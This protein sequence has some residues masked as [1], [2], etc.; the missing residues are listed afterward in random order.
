LSV[1]QH[2]AA[3]DADSLHAIERGAHAAP[4]SIL[5]VHYAFGRRLLRVNAPGA[6]RVEARARANGE[7]LAVLDQ[8]QTPGLFAGP[9]DSEAPY[10]LRVYWPGRVDEHEDP[11]SFASAL[12]APELQLMRQS[13]LRGVSGFLG[14]HVTTLEDVP[15]VRFAYWAPDA[16]SVAVAGDFNNWSDCRH[17]M[18]QC[19]DSG[20]WEVF[21]PRVDTGARYCFAVRQCDGDEAALIIDPF[22]RATETAPYPA[23]IVGAVLQHEWR[24]DRFLAIRRARRD[25]AAPVSIYRIEP[26]AWLARAER[27]AH[28]RQLSERLPGF[29][30]ALGFSHIQIALTRK[31]APAWM[32]SPPDSLGEPSAFADFIDVC[33]EAGL[34]VVLDWD[35]PEFYENSVAND[36]S[37]FIENILVD[38]AMAWLEEFHVDGLSI[39]V[40][41]VTPNLL[42]RLRQ[43]MDEAA[44]GALLIVEDA[45]EAGHSEA[46]RCEVQVWRADAILAA[47][48][49]AADVLQREGDD[50]LERT[51]LPITPQTLSH[52]SP[53][54]WSS[55][56][57]A[58]LRAVYAL[59]WLTP[60]MKL[61]H[62]G[63]EIGQ[64]QWPNDVVAWDMLDNPDSLFFLKLVR[65]L[66]STLRNEAPI[67]LSTRASQLVTWLPTAPPVIAYIRS[68]EAAA[69]L[70]VAM[71]RSDEARR[72]RLEA[73]CAGHWRELLNTDSHHYGGGDVGNYG[74]AHTFEN[75]DHPGIFFL[76]ITIPSRGA[77]IFRNDI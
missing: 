72:I 53:A 8:S 64:H 32:F 14:A 31:G 25:C 33:H 66:N 62:M 45:S 76:D 17:P 30:S 56:P 63:A 52:F 6:W 75:A 13:P 9:F 2:I 71:N 74:G 44:P 51:L 58:L 35:A 12:W 36:A 3:F 37:L 7:I 55:D 67:R 20:V 34:G 18:G 59:A 26:D 73:P 57:L 70:L 21:I 39:K 19:G 41:C 61:M 68:G 27:T 4:F 60:G 23:A 10:L 43:N 42:H 16:A 47:F 1:A 38:S 15:G 49:G 54:S 48:D 22:A 77:I 65:D 46:K 29:V 11:Y 40:P 24:D 69:P 50:R 28:W 5:G